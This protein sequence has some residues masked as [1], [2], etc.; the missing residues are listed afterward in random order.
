[1]LRSLSH[2]S[3]LGGGG[4][5]RMQM[6]V[7]RRVVENQG[8]G[9]YLGDGFNGRERIDSN[10]V[11][12]LVANHRGLAMGAKVPRDP[13]AGSALADR[14]RRSSSNALSVGV[15]ELQADQ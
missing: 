4:V 5:A 14:P 7:E 10:R 1:M 8:L 15:C 11:P 12:R 13:G 3:P 9:D 6:T 2:A